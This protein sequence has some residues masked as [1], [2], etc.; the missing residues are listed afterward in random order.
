MAFFHSNEIKTN[1]AGYSHSFNYR[2]PTGADYLDRV[3][4][5][6]KHIYFDS[7]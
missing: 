5:S 1:R 6:K 7:N 3:D 4:K 2:M